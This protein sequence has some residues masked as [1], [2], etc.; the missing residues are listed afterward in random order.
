MTHFSEKPL[1][2]SASRK[3]FHR[4]RKVFLASTALLLLLQQGAMA[5]TIDNGTRTITSS[6]NGNFGTSDLIVG[7]SGTG[8]L[9]IEDGGE[10]TNSYGYVGYA[11]GSNGTVTVRGTTS[12][13]TNTNPLY[14]G[15]NGNGSLTIE[16]GGT[17]TNTAAFLGLNANSTG[18]VT[19]TGTGSTWNSS[20][21]LK[22]G[23]TGTGVLTISNGGGVSSRDGYLGE[24]ANS[25]GTV[26]VTGQGSTWTNSRHLYVGNLGTGELTISQ[27]G[28]VSNIEGYVGYQ[29]DQANN[30]TGSG[31]V[32]VTGTGSTWTNSGALFVG[33]YGNGTLTIADG[34]KVSN[35][36]SSIGHHPGI[37]G[38]VTVTGAGSIWTNTGPLTLGYVGTST[39]TLTIANGGEVRVGTAGT[40]GTYDGTVTIARNAASTG[41]LNIGAAAGNAAAA[42]GTLSAA[43]LQFYSGTGKLVFNHTNTDYDFSA[44]ISSVVS[45]TGTIEH[46]AGSTELSGDSSGFSGTTNV[47]GG[48]LYVTGSLG[49]TVNAEN[50]GT[51]AG[52]GTIGTSSSTVTIGNGGTLSPGL[53][54][55]VGTLTMSGTLNLATGSTYVV[56]VSGNSSDVINLTGTVTIA[57]GTTLQISGTATAATY[58][59]LTASSLSGTFTTVDW[60]SVTGYEVAYDTVT[61]TITLVRTAPAQL[62]AEGTPGTVV[63]SPETFTGNV[64]VGQSGSGS[65]TIEDGGSVSNTDGFIGEQTG[66]TGTVT[67]TGADTSGN[68]STWTNSGDLYAGYSGTGTLIIEDGGAVSNT[69][70]YIGYNSGSSGE[71]IVRGTDA[72]GNASTWTN[73]DELWVGSYGS[74][75]LTIEDGGAVSNTIGYLGYDSGSSGAVTVTGTDAN[76]NA[77]NWTNSGELYVGN[78][79]DGELTIENGGSVSNTGGVI[80]NYSTGTGNVTVTGAGST[81]TNSSYLY[82]GQ[83]GNGEL[84][85]GDGGAVTNT[86]GSIGVYANSSGTV[87]V[88]GT[89]SNGNA[90]TWT[91]SGE[92]YAGQSGDA[93]LTIEDGGSVSNTD[94]YIGYNSSGSGAVTVTGTGSAWTNGGQLM[95]GR[96]GTGELTIEDGGTVTSSSGTIGTYA[97]GSGTVTVSGEDSIWTNGGQLVVGNLGT[98]ELTIASGGEVVVGSAGPSASI[99]YIASETGS[100]GTINIGAASGSSAT[101]AGTLNAASLVFGN[102]TGKLVFNHTNTD[103]DFSTAISTPS[104][105]SGSGTIEHLA[106]STKLSGDSS[107]FSGTTNVSGG[108]LYV[109]GSLGG[110]VNALTGGTLAGTGTIGTSSSV[111]TIGNGGRLSPGLDGAVGTLTMSGSLNLA[112][113]STYVVQVSGNSSDVIDLT[114]TVTI[115]SGTTLQI[116]GTATAQSYTILTASS[117][118][119]TF[120][121]VNWGSVTG[122]EVA[123]DETNGTITLVRTAASSVSSL[124]PNQSSV[125]SVMQSGNA[126]A[127]LVSAVSALDSGQQT[128]TLQQLSGQSHADMIG[129]LVKVNLSVNSTVNGRIRGVTGGVA[130]P[131]VPVL[132]YGEEK[133]TVTDD[134]FAAFEKKE[135]PADPDRFAVWANGF[136]S[137]GQAGAVNGGSSTST[138]TAGL[139]VGGDATVTGD[140]RAGVFG[141][142]SRSYFNDS[143]SKNNSSTYHAG[144]YAGTSWDALS[145]R[146]GLSYTWYDVS[147]K[148]N[149]SALDETVD[150][151]Y[152]ASSL[153]A[154]GEVSYRIATA[155]AAFEP[156][157]SLA[158]THL[159]TDGFTETGGIS[160]LTIGSSTSDTTYTTLGMRAS[161]DVYL[162][163]VTASLRGSLGWLYAFGDLDATRT[164]RFA[165]GSSFNVTGTPLD[166]NAALLETGVDF[167][168]TPS[169]TLGI[170]YTGQFGSIAQ[171]HGAN[172]RLRLQF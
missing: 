107:G 132:G 134:R 94:G 24:L 156:F 136:G 125:A 67:V 110:T 158:H 29:A 54:G 163:P 17:V 92:L 128:E 86:V 61:G 14:V 122:Y 159:K 69:Y 137:W 59:I 145:F 124:T 71:V 22:I 160:A 101:A 39:G 48:T 105:A 113:G 118:S 87:T 102:G 146:T 72:N 104:S 73:S 76:G 8:S 38:T 100:A 53:D 147:T 25:A 3:P 15:F 139:L 16:N 121:T 56:Q 131:T 171:E 90:S 112:S 117:L 133:K 36:N 35:T 62:V 60:G 34:G 89:D 126:P 99:I 37:T 47:S 95:V 98:G 150:G 52:T 108:T 2:I 63:N 167:N 44:A 91:N 127:D 45:G 96:V 18:T 85:I 79:G 151:Q 109:T 30:V 77:S 28:T 166:R 168:L 140:L 120:T 161:T 41:T 31:T 116:T 58:T 66:S 106:G 4:T 93:T 80:G 103:Y 170:T 64:T 50:G 10:V 42:A 5:E 119:G 138:E 88:T 55:S 165:T 9:T 33:F 51:L 162:G 157:A 32:T 153:N 97:G 43:S 114:G 20:G 27:G 111:V 83:S 164:A 1:S 74:G 141:G 129:N 84:T 40:N 65:L 12:T 13:W 78:G 49:G 143:S 81:W 144:A 26:T 82:A 130:A 6:D 115:A 21:D 148:R 155:H 11:A 7:N 135:V 70:G 57:S 19:V 154:F 152:D 142:F 169:S 123:Y 75:T 68:A 23:R 172:A 46:L 149:I